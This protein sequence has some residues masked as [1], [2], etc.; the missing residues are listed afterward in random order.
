NVSGA[1]LLAGGNNFTG[2]SNTFSGNVGIGTSTPNSPLAVF[3]NV[4]MGKERNNTVFN[5]IGDTIYLGAEQKYL[6]NTLL[7]PIG[8]S[9]DWINLMANPISAG[10]MFGTSG[11]STSNPHT[12]ITSLVVIKPSGRMGI[13][14]ASPADVGSE[15]Q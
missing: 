6:G 1:A 4:F 14:T 8:G 10:I 7:T 2:A 3:G 9:T 15:W 11:S 5:Q 13:G 12:N